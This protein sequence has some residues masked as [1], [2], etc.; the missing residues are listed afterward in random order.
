MFRKIAPDKWKHFFVGIAL[1][2]LIRLFFIYLFPVHPF[3][4][5]GLSVLLLF[6]ICYGFELFSLITGRGHYEV[7]DFVAGAFG[8]LIGIAATL[9]L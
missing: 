5:T 9:I 1:G 3:L 4:N 7:M 2:L 8:G 6:A